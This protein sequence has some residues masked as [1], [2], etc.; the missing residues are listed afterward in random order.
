MA[1]AHVRFLCSGVENM[2]S[3][4]MNQ[5]DGSGWLEKTLCANEVISPS[6]RYEFEFFFKICS[7]R[8]LT[9]KSS[10]CRRLTDESAEESAALGFRGIGGARVRRSCGDNGENEVR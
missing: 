10:V 4:S 7:R 9:S 8:R 3:D 1:V 2:P 6:L 5:W